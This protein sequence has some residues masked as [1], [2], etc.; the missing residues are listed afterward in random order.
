MVTFAIGQLN[1]RL[2]YALALGALLAACG[3]AQSRPGTQDSK[4]VSEPTFVGGGHILKVLSADRVVINRG[5]LDGLAADA[6]RLAVFPV[7]RAKDGSNNTNTEIDSD[8][9]L[10]RGAV[11]ELGPETA[12]VQL[13]AAASPVEVGDYVELAL[14]VPNGF[15]GDP[16][17]ELAALDI[18]LRTLDHDAPLYRLSDLTRDP[19]PARKALILQAMMG[20]IKAQTALAKTVFTARIEGGRFHGLGLGEA[21]ER[22]TPAD[23]EV[24]LMFMR[25]FPGKYIAHR[26][27]LVEIYA[28]WIINRTPDGDRERR[29]RLANPLIEQGLSSAEVGDF[30]GAE[31]AWRQALK[32]LPDDE[33]TKD[34]LKALE[35]IRLRREA[36]ERDPDDT[37]LRWAHMVALFDRSAYKLCVQEI[38]VLERQKYRPMETKRYRAMI[39]ARQQRYAEAVALLREIVTAGP[40]VSAQSWL[41]YSEHMAA[42]KVNPN[43]MDAQLALAR[44]H[45][46]DRAYDTALVA[47]R[48]AQDLAK[49]P[50]EMA[51]VREGQLRIG[52]LRDIDKLADWIDGDIRKHDLTSAE[53]RIGR[54]LALCQKV[55]DTKRPAKLLQRFAET[56]SE[57]WEELASL[58]WRIKQLRHEP[59]NLEAR[60]A[61]AWTMHLLGEFA[62]AK[63]QIDHVVKVDPKRAYA[64]QILARVLLLEGKLGDA[65][66]QA[67]QAIALDPGYAWPKVTLARIYVAKGQ[68]E[69]AVEISEIAWKRLPEENDTQETRRAALMAKEAAE[70]IAKGQDV[71]RQRLRLLRALVILELPAAVA[72]KTAEL[73][74]GTDAWRKGRQ[75]LA[76]TSSRQFK[77]EEV[78]QALVDATQ[79]R[80]DGEAVPLR[81]RLEWA[82]SA[83]ALRAKPRDSEM[84]V[85]TARALVALGRFHEAL[86]LVGAAKP[87]T[88]AADAAE[89]ARLGNEAEEAHRIGLD[90]RLSGNADAAEQMHRKA[91]EILLK[92]RS[93]RAHAMLWH[94]S[95]ALWAQGKTPQALELL[96]QSRPAAAA[97][98]D[99]AAVREVDLMIA[100]IEAQ[101]GALQ[102]RQVALDKAARHCAEED[103]DYCLANLYNSLGDLASTEGRLR[104]AERLLRQ[105]LHHGDRAGLRR[106]VRNGQ[107]TLADIFLV[108]GNYPEVDRIA[109][110]LLS[111]SRKEKDPDNERM[112]LMLLG[113]A[114]MRRGDAVAATKRFAEVYEVGRRS[115]NTWARAM[116]RLFEGRAWLDAAHA[117]EKAVPLLQQAMELYRGLNDVYDEGRA[118]LALGEA[119]VALGRKGPARQRLQQA[120]VLAQQIKSRGLTARAQI[121]LARLELSEGQ[122][123]I[124]VDLAGQATLLTEVAEV[125]EDRWRAQHIFARS[126]D[127]V[128]REDLAF[129]AY[130]IAVDQLV[131]ALAQSG[132]EADRD[133]ALGVGYA[134]EVFKDAVAFCLRTGKV[135]KA[136]E[137]LELSR[138]AALRRVFDPGKLQAQNAGLRQ[139]LERIKQAELQAVAS[140]KALDKEL[141]KPELE[142][143]TARV[144]ALGKVAAHTDRELRQLML[145]L[146]SKNPRMYQA[147]SIKAEDI[148]ALQNS[149]PEGA[150]VV[151]YF[152]ADDALYIFLITKDTTKPRAF[153]VEVGAKQLEQAVFDW[154]ASIAARNPMV[155]GKKRAEVLGA[156]PLAAQGRSLQL[157]RQLYAWLLG[158]IEAELASARTV[159]VVPYGPLYY[160]PIHAL[161]LP[162]LPEKPVYALEKYR[163]G[164]L[165]AAT[166]F[167]VGGALRQGERTLL[168]FGNPDG[169]LP[170]ARREVERLRSQAFPQAKVFYEADATK[171]KFLELAG[172]FRLIHLATHGVLEVDATASHLKMAGEPLT[173]YDITGLEG[174]DGRTELVVL[175]ACDTAL[176]LGK[177]TG[178]ELI[179]VASAFATAGAPALVASLW[180]VDDDAT[181]E[182]MSVFYSLLRDGKDAVGPI[183]TLEA[184]RRAQLHVLRA[185]K[186]GKNPWGE[187]AYWA[188]FQL[189]GDFR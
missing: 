23:V 103:N 78:R 161:A 14:P 179:S 81:L 61:V 133:G 47:Y 69:K 160:L 162:G 89:D 79:G 15:A 83:L 1:R 26:W 149:L 25:A 8:F 152:L 138:D 7:R 155:R 121:E 57:N 28:T 169:S 9:L 144:E 139:D 77:L 30:A 76:E 94:I 123:A 117:P 20:E 130:Q 131:A 2:L 127:A 135:E 120:L 168:A 93:N 91:R 11:V 39:L 187:P 146:N 68:Y 70:A 109:R 145:Q 102:A 96:R 115:G 5:Q 62:A 174:L 186:D 34:R 46:A 10:A 44:I 18:E 156:E 148:R 140:K 128:H 167:A 171:Q 180:E 118:Q 97:T 108:A 38:E 56:A 147:L 92:I 84:Q 63:E 74:A 153:R 116:A 33:K 42:A 106:L 107:G 16:L 85:R 158:P 125:A 176:Q 189:I 90:A 86:V 141:L 163:I 182:L 36:L 185:Q 60:L 17:F 75:L 154:R 112:A 98:G 159:L 100:D 88:P 67:E 49:T 122:G 111:E 35:G 29:V 6:R 173:V 183:D 184:L 136:L 50:A 177:S 43:S 151:E 66:R 31:I 181:S 82:E 142:R 114:A 170:G 101:Q 175:S 164:Y 104:D 58:R 37:A 71:E 157:S 53:T 72:E 51:H 105:S 41:E 32:L 21:F 124:A 19:S 113:A 166:R 48:A 80:S 126:L 65:E 45:E 27:K 64:W 55:G 129:A 54:V 24:F 172:Q 22:T 132:G 13:S 188:A 119:E 87:G 137:W 143:N 178:E 52:V 3:A 99:P 95:A 134:R 4:A 110:E 59:D 12:V 165:S 40:H 150:V 73:P